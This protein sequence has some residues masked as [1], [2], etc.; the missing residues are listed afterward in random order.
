MVSITRPEITSSSHRRPLAMALTKRARRSNC[1]GRASLRVLPCGSR[2]RRA[3]LDGGFCQGIVSN[4]PSTRSDASLVSSSLSRT[5]SLPVCTTTLATNW[6]RAAR[7][8]S[9]TALDVEP[10]SWV[11]RCASRHFMMASSISAAGTR[12]IDPAG[13]VLASPCRTGVDA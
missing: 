3:L 1:S 10:S 9:C 6:V 5:T 8:R 11:A 12:E 13:A 2:I 4:G 7:S